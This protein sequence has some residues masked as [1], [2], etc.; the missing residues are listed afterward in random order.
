MNI[1]YVAVG[2][3]SILG[4]IYMWR[5]PQGMWN[6]FAAEHTEMYREPEAEEK[7]VRGA[8]VVGFLLMVGGVVATIASALGV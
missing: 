7:M 1:T 8:P 2:V 6:R 4:G 5:R 3:M